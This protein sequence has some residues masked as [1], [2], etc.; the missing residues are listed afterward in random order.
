MRQTGVMIT[1][2]FSSIVCQDTAE[3]YETL[4][5]HVTALAFQ[6]GKLQETCHQTLLD[7]EL[8]KLAIVIQN[9][10]GESRGELDADLCHIHCF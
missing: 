1:D 4:N 8:V 6:D 7:P 9:G 5:L 2:C 3:D 10:L